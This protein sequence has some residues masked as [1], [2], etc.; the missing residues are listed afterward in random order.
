VRLAL[1]ALVACATPPVLM[2]PAAPGARADPYRAVVVFVHHSGSRPASCAPGGPCMSAP[3]GF[4]PG[5]SPG[6]RIFG[7]HGELLGDSAPDTSFAAVVEPGEHSF[8]GWT[9]PWS[10]DGAQSA[11]RVSVAAG[12]VYYIDVRARA[13]YG[14]RGKGPPPWWHE[15]ELHA[16]HR[17]DMVDPAQLVAH[18]VWREVDDEL[19][20][21]TLGGDFSRISLVNAAAA[22]APYALGPDDGY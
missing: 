10:G 15:L 2:R 11:L 21:S 4:H 20:I 22:T 13:Y 16:I 9:Q 6:V 19:A 5:G 14:S 18:T 7:E 3:A 8:V 17:G 1:F 12:R